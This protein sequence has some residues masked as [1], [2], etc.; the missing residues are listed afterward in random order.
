MATTP[1]TSAKKTK[2]TSAPSKKR[3]RDTE[4]VEL[5]TTWKDGDMVI[6]YPTI[7]ATNLVKTKFISDKKRMIVEEQGISQSQKK[8]QTRKNGTEET[9]YI[10]YLILPVDCFSIVKSNSPNPKELL[11][12]FKAKS[13]IIFNSFPSLEIFFDITTQPSLQYIKEKGCAML[14]LDSLMNGLFG[15]SVETN[16]L[17]PLFVYSFQMILKYQGGIGVYSETKIISSTI[18]DEIQNVLYP[19]IQAYKDKKTKEIPPVADL[20]VHYDYLLKMFTHFFEEM[21]LEIRNKK[22]GYSNEEGVGEI[23]FNIRSLHISSGRKL[24][25]K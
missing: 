21:F 7:P 10:I 14:L 24:Y 15:N 22:K 20:S 2:K 4:I 3:P 5:D 23:F 6:E 8:S 13:I 9:F 16:A 12:Q 18:L 1:K 25:I 19:T 17:H 11:E